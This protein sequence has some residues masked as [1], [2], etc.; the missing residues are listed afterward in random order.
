MAGGGIGPCKSCL[1]SGLY[2][3]LYM[4]CGVSSNV[5]GGM[6]VLADYDDQGKGCGLIP[7]KAAPL[8]RVLWSLFG[9][10]EG[11]FMHDHGSRGGGALG[12]FAVWCL[13]RDAMADMKQGRHFSSSWYVWVLRGTQLPT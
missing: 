9:G 2:G 8:M 10:I 12:L 6:L 4:I 11:F 3:L 1:C 13:N 7:S 5:V